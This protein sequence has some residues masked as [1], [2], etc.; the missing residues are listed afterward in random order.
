MNTEASDYI[1]AGVLSQ[2]DDQGM[3]HPVA[4]LKKHTPAESKYKMY[5]KEFLVVICCFE[6]WRA[7]LEVSLEP[8]EVLSDHRNLE[9]FMTSKQLNCRQV[10]WGNFYLVSTLKLPFLVVN[11]ELNWMI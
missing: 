7:H 3:L 4:Y 10:S 8:V 1:S 5:D 9:Y 2:S 11:K 6:E